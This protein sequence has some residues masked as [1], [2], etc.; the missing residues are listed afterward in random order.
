MKPSDVP[1]KAV[2]ALA[3]NHAVKV[4]ALMLVVCV[5]GVL[6]CSSLR[7]SLGEDSSGLAEP[8][9]TYKMGFVSFVRGTLTR[10]LWPA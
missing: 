4:E 8:F 6:M 1:P 9:V 2:P 3:L 5:D 10:K 7:A